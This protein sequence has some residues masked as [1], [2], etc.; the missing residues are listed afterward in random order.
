MVTGKKGWWRRWRG[1]RWA[2]EE[3]RK[4]A[5]RRSKVVAMGILV[6]SLE[7]FRRLCD[8]RI[9]EQQN[10]SDIRERET[11]KKGF[12]FWFQRL[13]WWGWREQ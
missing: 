11:K 9:V 1:W 4:K 10:N 2:A 13:G 6:K 7:V 8:Q 3:Q 12:V 5:K